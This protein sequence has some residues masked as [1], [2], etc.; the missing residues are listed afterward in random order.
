MDLR[1]VER[2]AAGALCSY[3]RPA[4]RELSDSLNVVKRGGNNDLRKT[5]TLSLVIVMPLLVVACGGDDGKETTSATTRAASPTEFP[6]SGPVTL[7]LGYFANVTHAV[8]L[9]GLNNGIFAQEL[10]ANVTIDPKTF[11]AGPDV[12]TAIFAG[13][14]DASYIGQS[15]AVNGY[16]QS[17]GHDVRIVSGAASGG[18]ALVVKPEIT[19]PAQ[20]SGR[21]IASPQLGNTQDIALRN[22]LKQNGVPAEE[23]GG[24]VKVIPTANADALTAFQNGDLDGGWAPEPWA[25]RL[26]QEGGGH[27]LVDEKT[28]WP[29]GQFATTVLIVRTNFLS[30][31]PDTVQ[32]LISANVKTVQWIKQHTEEAKIL[33]NQQI[34]AVTSK[35]LPKAVID[36]A[37]PNVEF[38]YDPIQS[39]VETAAK[40]AYDL[41]L[42]QDNP[43]LADLF[44]LDILNIVL[45]KQGLTAVSR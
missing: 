27:I 33:V 18:A 24:D 12:I 2:D 29:N 41:G 9:V 36:A 43:D 22:W 11:N 35:A 15:P 5:L 8:P 25:T 19:E 30:D 34:E 23:N 13:E 7:H 40:Q 31:H 45:A 17:D 6:D 44:S 3:C 28:L 42:L 21:R 14:L 16:V 4:R 37:F 32:K 10:G 38:T 39:S 1:R 26:V 20:L